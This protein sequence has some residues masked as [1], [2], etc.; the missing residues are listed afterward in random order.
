MDCL[1]LGTGTYD[2]D[3]G[4]SSDQE[5]YGDRDSP[6][7]D[8]DHRDYAP[9]SRMPN[10][11]FNTRELKPLVI[12]NQHISRSAKFYNLFT[13]R[14]SGM[15]ISNKYRPHFPRIF[16]LPKQLGSRN[17]YGISFVRLNYSLKK[18]LHHSILTC[19]LMNISIYFCQ[20]GQ[21]GTGLGQAVVL[22]SSSC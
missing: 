4:V 20:N 22:L 14:I 11:K 5:S 7:I 18:S 15:L 8:H 10:R 17:N 12:L 9:P 13:V 16:R 21:Y 6:T 19:L 2:A 1:T 3:W